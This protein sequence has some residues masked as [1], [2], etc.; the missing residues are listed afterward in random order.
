M[1]NKRFQELVL[2]KLDKLDKLDKK[3]DDFDKRLHNF[4]EK[5]VN[6]GNKLD[7]LDKR[8]SNT[9]CD[10]KVMLKLMEELGEGQK[11]LEKIVLRMENDTTSKVRGLFEKC[12]IHNDRLNDHD[13]RLKVL[14]EKKY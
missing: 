6:F 2:K 7:F 13:A 5:L 14:E 9:E 11:R 1:D 3:Q 4:D 10:T 12:D 8:Q